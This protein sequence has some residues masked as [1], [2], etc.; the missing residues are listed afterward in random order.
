MRILVGSSAPDLTCFE[1]VLKAFLQDLHRRRLSQASQVR[2][3]FLLPR[4]FAHLAQ[5]GVQDLREVGEAHL[6]SFARALALHRTRKGRPLKPWS[7]HAY[8]GCVRGLFTCLKRRGWLLENPARA[9]PLPKI[10]ALPRVLLSEEQVRRLMTDAFA[11]TAVGQR[12]RAILETLYGTGVRPG[13][14]TRLNVSDLD[15]SR[16]VLLVRNG[17]GRKDRYVPVPARAQQ[18]L[19]E[20]LREGRCELVRDGRELFVAKDGRRLTL[21]TLGVLV[22]KH[23]KQAGLRTPLTP[24]LF[25][26]ACATHLLRGG[27][28]V[29][30]VQELL[31]H[32]NLQTTV[33]YTRVEI[34]DLARMVRRCH[35]REKPR[36]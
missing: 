25:R 16:G 33:I 21:D 19:E 15:L 14:C 23:G 13:E 34:S 24:Y 12:D 11:D 9:L 18:A 32:R 3:R 27:A 36:R 6:M 31:G 29:R 26:H 30:H 7:R 17:K 28:D 4:L 22:S 1:A 20:Y 10:K 5:A 8:L 2:A 35:P